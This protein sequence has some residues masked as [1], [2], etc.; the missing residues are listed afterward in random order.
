MVRN[1]SRIKAFTLVELLV[2]IGIISVLI[3]I[4]LPALQR[5]RGAA[6]SVGC[7]SNLHS[8]MQAVFEYANDNNGYLVPANWYDT[9]TPGPYG[10]PGSGW[11]ECPPSDAILLGKYTDGPT[12]T[13]GFGQISANSFWR[14]PEKDWAPNTTNQAP[15]STCYSMDQDGAAGPY[16][17]ETCPVITPLSTQGLGGTP[18]SP[19]E[20][21]WEYDYKLSSIR[22]SSRML[23]FVCSTSERFEPG[24][25][26]FGDPGGLNPGNWYYTVTTSYYSHAI[27]HP[28]NT[29]NVSFMDGH[30]ETLTNTPQ[31]IAGYK[32]LGLYSAFER[33][34][35]VVSPNAQ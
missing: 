16:V 23:A 31:T 33:G 20:T 25:W 12:C 26:F 7:Q 19:T 13:N 11:W 10:G 3:A 9:A 5:A 1:K 35:F 8:I 27:R 2:V 17:N 18:N 21:G 28:G 14:C 32:G 15:D 34:D 30:V 6:K 24:G 4:L 22:S 29:T